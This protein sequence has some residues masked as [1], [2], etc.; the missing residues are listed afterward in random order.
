MEAS[1]NMPAI[2]LDRQ[3][4]GESDLLVTAYTALRGKVRLLARGAKKPG[5]K[6]AGHVEPLTRA[7]IMI[8]GG[9]RRDYLGGALTSSAYRGIRDDLNKIYF[10]GRAAATY[11]RLTEENPGEQALFNL[12]VEWLEI[13]D[14]QLVDKEFT[15][16]RGELLFT[17]FILNFLSLTGHRP[18]LREC[19]DC[20]KTLVPD[21]NRFDL[22]SGGLICPVCR[23]RREAADMSRARFIVPASDDVIKTLRFLLERSLADAVRLVAKPRTAREAYDLANRFLDFIKSE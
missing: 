3:D 22:Q 16:W 20:Q 18:Q 15:R 5:S 1:S 17:A 7:D 19:V 14:S 12:L 10:A 21:E 6:L 2:I 11:R 9:R 8:I 13:L 23:V 4:Y